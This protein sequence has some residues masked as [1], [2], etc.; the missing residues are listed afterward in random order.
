MKCKTRN[1]NETQTCRCY[2]FGSDSN[3]KCV[4]KEGSFLYPCDPGCCIGG[5]PGQC[6]DVD[7]Q[8]AFAEAKNLIFI[9]KDGSISFKV[10]SVIAII[11]ISL[12]LASTLSLFSK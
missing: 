8:P 11:L 7:P 6:D 1:C 2:S 10:L 4:R 9:R 12:V 5:C 3:Q